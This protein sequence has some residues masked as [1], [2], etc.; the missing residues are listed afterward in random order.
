L[1]I[2][3]DSDKD[4]SDRVFDPPSASATVLRSARLN[5]WPAMVL[6]SEPFEPML[7]IVNSLVFAEE[8][9]V[10]VANGV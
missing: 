2:P 10:Y 8:I 3:S 9:A 7:R 4:D 6:G 1:P 5:G